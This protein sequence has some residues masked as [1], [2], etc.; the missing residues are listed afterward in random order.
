MAYKHGVSSTLTP[1]ASIAVD[2]LEQFT[3]VYI[4]TAPLGQKTLAYAAT[5]LNVPIVV[6]DLADFKSKF[7]WCDDWAQFTLCEAADAHFNN[8]I[9]AVGPIIVICISDPSVSTEQTASVVIT[10]GVGEISDE[11]AILESFSIADKVLGTDYTVEY[12]T[13]GTKL[14]VTALTTL[15]SP[16]T[17][18]YDRMTAA[19]AGDF[20]DAV[21]ALDF[22]YQYTQYIPSILLAPTWSQTKSVRDALVAKAALIGN[23]YRDIVYTDI[24]SSND[25]YSEAITAK[26]TNGYSSIYEKTHW[27]KASYDGKIYNLST[28]AAVAK[29]QTDFAYENIPYVSPSNKKIAIDKL[30]TDSGDLLLSEVD[31]NALNASGITTAIYIGGSF[32]TWGPHNSNYSYDNE[33]DIDLAERLDSSIAMKL[34]IANYFQ[35]NFVQYIDGPISVRDGNRVTTEAQ[36]WLNSLVSIGALIAGRIEFLPNSNPASQLASGD[37]KFNVTEAN[38]PNAK[39][40]EFIITPDYNALTDL[41]GGEAQ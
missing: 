17:V 37:F 34:F 36:Q 14:I 10:G 16:S 11:Y 2:N 30:V 5:I 22:V 12:N 20:D 9:Q 32:K 3:P 21:S 13:E 19:V 25:T 7:G 6:S 29:C 28:L 1:S 40:I 27:P 4:G 33:S 39:S 35:A 18:T 15:T 8:P 31:A 24:T 41:I 23:H 38:S 26:G